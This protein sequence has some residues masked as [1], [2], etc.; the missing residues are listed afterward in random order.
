MNDDHCIVPLLQFSCLTLFRVYL[1]IYLRVQ[2]R[3]MDVTVNRIKK[4]NATLM[5]SLKTLYCCAD[6][7]IIHG[8]RLIS[9]DLGNSGELCYINNL[10]KFRCNK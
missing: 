8:F 9:V 5:L 1:E 2:Q 7:G 10:I 6:S 3:Y 4:V